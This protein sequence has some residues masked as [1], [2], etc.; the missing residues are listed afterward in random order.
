M[1]VGSFINPEDGGDM[2]LRTWV[3]FRL[4]I[5]VISQKLELFITTVVRNS[6]RIFFYNSITFLLG[7]DTEYNPIVLHCDLNQSFQIVDH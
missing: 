5:G 4:T 7:I 6:N 3:D 2:F 1:I